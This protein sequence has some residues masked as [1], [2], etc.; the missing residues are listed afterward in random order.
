MSGNE[1]VSDLFSRKTICSLVARIPR[2]RE[3]NERP[4][5][6]FML[7]GLGD[8]YHSATVLRTYW[9]DDERLTGISMTMKGRSPRLFGYETSIESSINSI[10][11]EQGD[12]LDKLILS[13]DNCGIKALTVRM[14][15]TTP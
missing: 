3:P 9:N 8:L 5:T 11:I 15:T 2:F 6:S 14:C 7:L 1:N 12:W 10:V 13:L 4:F